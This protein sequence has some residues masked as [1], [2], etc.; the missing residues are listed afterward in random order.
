MSGEGGLGVNKFSEYISVKISIIAT[1]VYLMLYHGF[2][3]FVIRG[4]PIFIIVAFISYGLWR[5]VWTFGANESMSA[6]KNRILFA[7][8]VVATTSTPAIGVFFS[9]NTK[10]GG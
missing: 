5:L 4:A 7:I 1:G 2:E 9:T 10:I 8:H 3:G 6:S